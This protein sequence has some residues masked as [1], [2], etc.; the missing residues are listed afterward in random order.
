LIYGWNEFYEDILNKASIVGDLVR[1]ETIDSVYGIPRGGIPV[2]VA[3][4]FQYGIPIVERPTDKSLIVDDF[5]DTGETLKNYSNHHNLVL[6]M[7][8]YKKDSNMLNSLVFKPRID[9]E[10]TFPWNNKKQKM[11]EGFRTIYQSVGETRELVTDKMVD[12]WKMLLDG[13]GKEKSIKIDFKKTHSRKSITLSFSGWFVDE[14]TFLPSTYNIT[15]VADLGNKKYPNITDVDLLVEALSHRL[16]SPHEFA[17]SIYEHLKKHYNSV[18]L[19][20][21]T[22]VGLKS[23]EFNYGGKPE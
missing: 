8:E 2:A 11:A 17:D 1:T 10:P 14:D 9:K 16:V 6:V 23:C 5:Y 13:Y 20:V 19:K 4:A 3:I 7:S 15:M 21:V 18:V 12:T 22:V